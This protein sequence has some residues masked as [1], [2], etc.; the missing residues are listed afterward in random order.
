V[1]VRV[2]DDVVEEGGG[3]RLVVEAELG[4]DLRGAPGMKDEILAGP[5]LLALVSARGEPEGP[6][7]QVAID[8]GVVRGDLCQQLVDELLMTLVSL[9]NCHT[10]IVRGGFPAT[11]R[12]ISGGGDAVPTVNEGRPWPGS[13][14]ERHAERPAVR[15]GYCSCWRA[16][17]AVAP[18]GGV[19]GGH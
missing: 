8:T 5:A 14:A 11:S 17:R 9:D 6:R 10:L 18:C 1:G 13:G 19:S 3:D 2:L 4:R 12:R 16:W 7:D 15:R